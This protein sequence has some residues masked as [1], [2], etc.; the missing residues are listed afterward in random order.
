MVDVFLDDREVTGGGIQAFASGRELRN[1][2]QHSVFVKIG[3]LFFDADFH[4]RL[5]ANV[6]AIPIRNAIGRRA[7]SWSVTA[8]AAQI[9]GLSRIADVFL[10]AGDDQ[11]RRRCEER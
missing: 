7:G 8:N 3:T 9:L 4:R 11:T 2:D 10:A 5:A 1:S 6:V